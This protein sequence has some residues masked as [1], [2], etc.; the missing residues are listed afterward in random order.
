[1]SFREGKRACSKVG[2]NLYFHTNLEA[3]SHGTVLKA[4]NF[5]S[6]FKTLFIISTHKL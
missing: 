3:N 6:I 4:D 2:D 5:G 1:M